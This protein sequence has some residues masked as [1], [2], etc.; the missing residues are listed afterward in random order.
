MPEHYALTIM[1][2]TGV[3]VA[4]GYRLRFDKKRQGAARTPRRWRDLESIA[5]FG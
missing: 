1:M 2:R 5:E 4:V 3:G